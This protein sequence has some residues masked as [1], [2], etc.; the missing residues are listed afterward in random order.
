[1][2]THARNSEIL[3]LSTFTYFGSILAFGIRQDSDEMYTDIPLF[4]A[5]TYV[6]MGLLMTLQKMPSSACH[7]TLKRFLN[8]CTIL[9]K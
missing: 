3:I 1:M 6:L 9:L 5:A 7:V 8:F 4:R 2:L